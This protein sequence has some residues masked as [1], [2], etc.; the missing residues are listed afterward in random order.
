M[1]PASRLKGHTMKL[2]R[3]KTVAEID[4]ALRG[5]RG[6]RPLIEI[7]TVDASVK[8]VRIGTFIISGSY[9]IEIHAEQPFDIEKRHRLTATTKGFPPAISYHDSDYTARTAGEEFGEGVEIKIDGPIKVLIDDAGEIVGEADEAAAE[10]RV[11][12][13]VP[14]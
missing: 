8:A 4:T 3:I 7:T 11:D 10:P 2:K 9:G 5:N 14:F 1:Q 13:D 6:G 12:Q